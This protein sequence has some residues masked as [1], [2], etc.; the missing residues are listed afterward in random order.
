M[1]MEFRV[2]KPNA[3]LKAATSTPPKTSFG[4]RRRPVGVTFKTK[5]NSPTA[6][7][8]FQ[9][10]SGHRENDSGVGEN[11]S[12]FSRNHCSRSPRN[13]IRLHPGVVF[14]FTPESCSPCPG[15]RSTGTDDCDGIM[16]DRAGGIYL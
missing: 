15:I 6:P 4:C 11:R 3:Y 8:I 2:R 1:L 13:P 7:P 16:L 9:K 14:A 12:P 5:R 10:H